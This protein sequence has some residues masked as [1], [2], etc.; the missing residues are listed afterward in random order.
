MHRSRRGLVVAFSA[1][2][3]A[4]AAFAGTSLQM[5]ILLDEA[6]FGQAHAQSS[7]RP[8]SDA[9]N[10]E[11]AEPIPAPAPGGAGGSESTS[12]VRPPPDAAANIPAEPGIPR[13]PDEVDPDAA[14][15][16]P[17]ET[18]GFQ[19]DSNLWG[20]IRQGAQGTVSIPDEKAGVLVDSSGASWLYWRA[21][22]GPLQEFGAWVIGGMIVLLALFFLIRGRIRIEGGRSGVLIERF[23]GIERF[24]HWMLATSFILLAL[25]G[26][27]LLYGKDWVMPYVG[28]A[29]FADVTLWG[30]WLH[31]NIAWPFMLALV[32]IFIF[33]IWHNIP[34]WTDVK[35]IA[36]GGGFI[37]RS[38][39]H[40][41]KFNAG[42]KVVLG[43][44]SRGS[45]CC[46]PT[47]SR[48]SP[49]PSAS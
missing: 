8:P 32:L 39:P 26:L 29:A 12:S 36:R 23:A 27:N 40:A 7:V 28:K 16:G 2:A 18:Q 34:T 3:L 41:K 42:Q 20:A 48:C 17:L 4:L 30:K 14:Q 22:G 25:S 44:R 24:A 33:W 35:W 13:A 38:H 11:G 9:A 19:S 21:K 46:S 31:N 45:R 6:L 43:S 10:V 15:P 49:R 5:G 1:L 47:R 37:G